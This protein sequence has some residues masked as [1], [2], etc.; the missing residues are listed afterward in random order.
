MQDG[1]Y[2]EV[3]QPGPLSSCAIVE[4]YFAI[5]FLKLWVRTNHGGGPIDS[6]MTGVISVGPCFKNAQ[7]VSLILCQFSDNFS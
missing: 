5:N 3:T 4:F 7:I 6:A 1:F 2:S